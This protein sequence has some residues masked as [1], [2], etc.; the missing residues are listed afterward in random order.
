MQQQNES[1]ESSDLIVFNDRQHRIYSLGIECRP[2]P[3]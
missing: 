3:P 2:M 1:E